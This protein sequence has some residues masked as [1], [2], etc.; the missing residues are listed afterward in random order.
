MPIRCNS[1]HLSIGHW[2]NISTVA[3]MRG[4]VS[5]SIRYSFLIR[6]I[7]VI[8][9]VAFNINLQCKWM[10]RKTK[11]T[12]IETFWTCCLFSNHVGIKF[13]RQPLL[14]PHKC[15]HSYLAK[16]KFTIH[17]SS[18][19]FNECSHIYVCLQTKTRFPFFSHRKLGDGFI[20]RWQRHFGQLWN[21]ENQHCFRSAAHFYTFRIAL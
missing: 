4:C 12:W 17:K 15:C 6:F 14:R 3:V 5:L 10:K 16:V 7:I 13:H 21:V 18:T 1:C 11:E 9:S 8:E 19:Y 2:A 20:E